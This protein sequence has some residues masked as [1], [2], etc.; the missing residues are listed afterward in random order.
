M[1]EWGVVGVLVAL[2]G[3]ISAVTAPLIKLNSSIVALTNQVQNILDGLGEFKK[4][5]VDN[6][7]ELKA[8]D[9]EMQGR[10]DD[11]EHRI[12]VLESGGQKAQAKK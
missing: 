11:H 8:A 4:R 12:T 9:G 10:L 7:N 5:Y 1:S 2:V 6:L 3:L